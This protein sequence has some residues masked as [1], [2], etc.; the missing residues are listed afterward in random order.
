MEEENLWYCLNRGT[1]I[2]GYWHQ[3]AD[4]RLGNPPPR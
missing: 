3:R 4:E 2:M 1:G